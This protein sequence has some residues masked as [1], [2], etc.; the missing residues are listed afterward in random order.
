MTTC[1]ISLLTETGVW[2]QLRVVNVGLYEA[3]NLKYNTNTLSFRVR[4]PIK[5]PEITF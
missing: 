2:L 3:F 1:I 5:D 4:G